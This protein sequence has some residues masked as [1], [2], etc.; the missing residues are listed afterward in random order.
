[1][2]GSVG[3]VGHKK[4]TG[5]EVI[6]GYEPA[7]FDWPSTV[8]WQEFVATVHQRVDNSAFEYYSALKTVGVRLENEHGP[9]RHRF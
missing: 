3:E 8:V 5:S 4:I 9:D 6:A 2:V 1:V 7:E